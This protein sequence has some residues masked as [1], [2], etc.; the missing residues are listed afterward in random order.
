M[1]FILH[2]SFDVVDV[3]RMNVALTRAKSSV[4]V[5]GHAATL[6]RS[7]ETWRMIVQDARAR[8]CLV[9]VREVLIYGNTP[10]LSSRPT[11]LS[12]P[13]QPNGLSQHRQS[14]M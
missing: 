14:R 2:Y 11:S 9:D 10:N 6:E 3:R 12:S 8:F 7:D 13:L 4:F 1:E 5:L